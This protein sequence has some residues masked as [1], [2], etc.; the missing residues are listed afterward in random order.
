MSLER[1][2]AAIKQPTEE[3]VAAACAEG[4]RVLRYNIFE[5]RDEV[6]EVFEGREALLAWLQRTPEGIAWSLESDDGAECRYRLETGDFVNGGTWRY[7]LDGEG[8]I[9][10]L[11]HH[12]DAI[13]LEPP[14]I[15]R[16]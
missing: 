1:W 3:T 15:P 9:T 2:L 8:L 13:S 16:R 12:A 4:V 14:E 10:E 7:A 6:G 5:D 11:H